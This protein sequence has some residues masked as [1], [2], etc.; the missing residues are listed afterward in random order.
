MG[1]EGFLKGEMSRREAMKTAL[2][3]G[4]YAA[5][6]V[7]AAAIPVGVAAA[8]PPPLGCSATTTSGGAGVTTNVHELGRTSGRFVFSWDAFA[9]PDKYDIFYQGVLLFSTG[10]VSFTGTQTITYSGT[11]TRVTVVVTG[12]NAFTAWTYVVNCPVPL[13]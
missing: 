6:V 12:S 8:T 7:V 1:D 5:P 3:A 9:I 13:A 4:A 2:K 10:F 11:S